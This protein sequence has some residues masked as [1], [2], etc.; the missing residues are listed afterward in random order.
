AARL[1]AVVPD[2]KP[3]KKGKSSEDDVEMTDL[4]NAPA[5]AA[6]ATTANAPPKQKFTPITVRSI[7]EIAGVIPPENI[8]NLLSLTRPHPSKSTFPPL[9]SAVTD[10]VADGWS[11]AQVVAQL[12]AAVLEDDFMTSRQKAG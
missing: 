3:S 4:D 10:L 5:A 12:Y 9:Q 7:E 8:S 6:E 11:A 2:T 1:H